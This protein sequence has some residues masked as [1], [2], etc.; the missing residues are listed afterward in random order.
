[1]KDLLKTEYWPSDKPMFSCVMV[2]RGNCA[3]VITTFSDSSTF[4]PFDVSW[5][6][7]GGM[8]GAVT[9]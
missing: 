8:V 4:F 7:L 1:M 5:Q 9:G 6:I 3:D 2:E